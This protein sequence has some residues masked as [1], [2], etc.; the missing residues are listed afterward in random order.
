MIIF[1]QKQGSGEFRVLDAFLVGIDPNL[2]MN[3]QTSPKIT[4]VAGSAASSYESVMELLTGIAGLVAV[5][6]YRKRS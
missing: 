1:Y 2:S 4:V 3:E 6:T 5:V